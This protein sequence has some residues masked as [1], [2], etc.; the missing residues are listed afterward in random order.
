MGASNGH[1]ASRITQRPVT[2]GPVPGLEGLR[3]LDLSDDLAGAYC[4]SLSDVGATVTRV[5]HPNGHSLRH[6]SVNGDVG[7][8][9]DPD[10]ALFRFLASS[11]DS[12]VLD[13]HTP[14]SGATVAALAA[15]AD[16]C[17]ISTFGGH[18]A[19]TDAHVDPVALRA[20]HSELVVVSLSAF[21]LTAACLGAIVGLSAAGSL[22]FPAQPRQQRRPPA[23]RRGRVRPKG[24]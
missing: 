7:G 8:D 11:Q 2:G 23:C 19:D 12:V 13:L 15:S 3:V 4:A 22:G 21:G 10:G 17:I 6:W 9:G 20:A 18:G 24:R 16:V 14:E 5:E 1:S